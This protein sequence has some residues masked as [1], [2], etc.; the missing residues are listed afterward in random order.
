MV[1]APRSRPTST[2]PRRLLAQAAAGRAGVRCW[3][4]SASWRSATPDKLA[5][6]PKP[7][8]DGPIQAMLAA[9]AVSWA[10]WWAARCWWPGIATACHVQHLVFSPDGLRGA[11][12]QDP[13]V[14]LR[15]S[16]G[17]RAYDEGAVSKP[18]VG[19]W[20]RGGWA[21]ARRSERL[22]R[23]ALS[24]MFTAAHRPMDLICVPAAFTET[25]GSVLA[26]RRARAWCWP[27]GTRRASPKCIAGADALHPASSI[28]DPPSGCSVGRPGAQ[29]ISR[30]RPRRTA[31]QV[32]RHR[33]ESAG[34]LRRSASAA[35][36][37]SGPGVI[38][39]AAATQ[40]HHLAAAS[41]TSAA[42]ALSACTRA[43]TSGVARAASPASDS[44]TSPGTRPGHGRILAG[45]HAP[46]GR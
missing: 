46:D 23:P 30:G 19:R 9:G 40:G 18:G 7:P 22:L 1:L 21:T 41:T 11:L 8:G 32:G 37:S 33:R 14:P 42:A 26:V 2:A 28:G 29:L 10:G 15:H 34:E 31:R 25:T 5:R 44:A 20:L 17:A 3:S 4:T 38:C 24:R 36:G 27:S 6:S 43:S 16:G 39:L 13:P 45:H 12:R 35:T